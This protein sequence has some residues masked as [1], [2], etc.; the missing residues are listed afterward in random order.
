MQKVNTI[1]L[2]GTDWLI[3]KTY[4]RTNLKM[5]VGARMHITHFWPKVNIYFYSRLNCVP[6]DTM[7]VKGQP[8]QYWIIP[9]VH[10]SY[11]LV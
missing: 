4:Q 8:Y 3:S 7:P 2:I 5:R 10:S 11:W 9:K 1:F 6:I